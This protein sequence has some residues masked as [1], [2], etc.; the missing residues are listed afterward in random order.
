MGQLLTGGK[1]SWETGG[2]DRGIGVCRG[3]D[4][5]ETFQEDETASAKAYKLYFP[6]LPQLS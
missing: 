2:I 5:D 6:P 1:Q 3:N 4:K